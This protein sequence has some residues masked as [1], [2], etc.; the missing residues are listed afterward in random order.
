MHGQTGDTSA[1]RGPLQALRERLHPS[2]DDL[3]ARIGEAIEPLPD[4]DDP[5]FAAAFDRYA[6]C[7]VVLLGESSHGTSEF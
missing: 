3:P 6:R 7:R 2:G 1:P 4:I 5:A